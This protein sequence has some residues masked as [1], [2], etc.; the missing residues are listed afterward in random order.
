MKTEEIYQ[1]DS[2]LYSATEN[3]CQTV[4]YRECKKPKLATAEGQKI[5]VWQK[6]GPQ[7]SGEKK[8]VHESSGF[9]LISLL[10]VH[11]F[12]NRLLSSPTAHV[13]RLKFFFFHNAQTVQFLPI[14]IQ[15]NFFSHSPLS[16]SPV[17][18][19][20]KVQI[21]LSPDLIPRSS[22]LFSN[23]NTDY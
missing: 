8:D 2:P 7:K 3:K 11:I 12:T 13:L 19:S 15:F 22:F 23:S 16:S 4:K 5:R 1:S 6:P 17:H 14:L 9:C 10:Y 18:N 21:S 20:R